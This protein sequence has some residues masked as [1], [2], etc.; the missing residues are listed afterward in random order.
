MNISTSRVQ[1]DVRTPQGPLVRSFERRRLRIYVGQMLTDMLCI[2]GGFLL[3]GGLYLGVWPAPIALIEA[4]VL[5][6]VYLTLA[7]ASLP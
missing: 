2:F 1:G 3:G 6:P 5:L 7:T 4:Q